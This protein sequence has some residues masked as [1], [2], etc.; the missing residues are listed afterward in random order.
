MSSTRR[1]PRMVMVA[2][3]CGPNRG[4]ENGVGW[5]RAVQAG[6]FADT[7]VLCEGHECEAEIR[8][9]LE[10][11]GPVPGVQ[12]VFVPLSKLQLRLQRV[13][14][15]YYLA[16]RLWH[17][18]AFAVAKRLHAEHKFDLAHQVNMVGYREP[19]LLWQLRIPFVWGPI[20]GTQNFPKRFLS[21][22]R[23]R[24]AAKEI[25]RTVLNRLQLRFSRSVH[26]AARRTSALLA[27]NSTSRL[28]LARAC[29]VAVT[30][31]LETGVVSIE[32]RAAGPRGKGE[33]LRILWSGMIEPRKALPLLLEALAK[34]PTSTDWELRVLG[35]GP[36]M[37]QSVSLAKRLGISD[38]IE[39]LGWLPL[40][41]AMRQY[42]WADVFVFTSM[43][44]TSGNVVLEALSRGV[45]VI[46]PD[47]QGV[48]D[49]VTHECGMKLPVESA[50]Q[51]IRDLASAIAAYHADPAMQTRLSEGAIRRAEY[52][53]WSKQGD[54]MVAVYERVLAESG[55]ELLVQDTADAARSTLDEVP[56]APPLETVS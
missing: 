7:W 24:D 28:D 39:W 46:C 21:I 40:A 20:G 53:L 33:P 38:R 5:N 50:E 31:M 14:G 27:A 56:V 1:R 10:T 2:Y 8:Q 3:V 51:F 35:D 29:R 23:K 37:Q 17:R 22:L 30:Q 36:L 44:D 55:S 15:C 18:A 42:D 41:A 9:H 26:Q 4:S 6:R 13:P 19:G 11:H 25:V 12:F 49:M 43:R 34:L 47:H 16:Y 32:P 52:Y 48:A 45:P 54:R